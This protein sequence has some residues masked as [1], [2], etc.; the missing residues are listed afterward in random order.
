MDSASSGDCS[1]AHLGELEADVGVEMAFNNG[2]EQ[3]VVNVGGA[4]RLDLGCDAFAKRVEGN[5]NALPV[6]RS[7]T[8]NA[9]SGRMPAMKRELS[10]APRLECSQ[11]RRNGRLCESAIKAERRTDITCL[12]Q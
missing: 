12:C 8:R 1:R 3:L 4:M 9:S 5:G 6:D 7:A 2:V 11:K 10:R